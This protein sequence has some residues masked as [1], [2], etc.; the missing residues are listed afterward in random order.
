MPR[1][2]TFISK[3]AKSALGTTLLVT[4]GFIGVMAL[5]MNSWSPLLQEQ[6]A[7]DTQDAKAELA[8]FSHLTLRVASLPGSDP[9]VM[10]ELKLACNN[11]GE[12][13]HYYSTRVAAPL[14]QGFKEATHVCSQVQAVVKSGLLTPGA[15]SSIIEP[16]T[17][18]IDTRASE[19]LI[20]TAH[21]KSQ[22]P[23][24]RGSLHS[25]LGSD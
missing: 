16:P 9:E 19:S 15:L 13:E 17:K 2:S 5:V 10:G 14:R 21:F 12:R 23:A 11:I 25:M 7:L 18:T 20:N 4:T 24:A 1:L 22:T 3:Q 6:Y 8:Q